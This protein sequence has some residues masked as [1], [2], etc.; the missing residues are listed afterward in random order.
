MEGFSIF[1]ISVIIALAALQWYI[2]GIRIHS[3]LPSSKTETCQEEKTET[4]REEYD[5]V[6]EKKAA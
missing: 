5:E 6:V 4:C 1:Y 2:G 3:N